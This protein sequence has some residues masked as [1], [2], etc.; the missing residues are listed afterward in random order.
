MNRP[1]ESDN[2]AAFPA[3][4]KRAAR[5]AI[6]RAFVLVGRDRRICQHLREAELTTLWLLEDWGLEWTVV[7]DHG[8]LEFHRGRVGKPNLTFAWRTAEAFF[9]QIETGLPVED[10][11]ELQGDPAWKKLCEPL[12]D[13]F[14]GSLRGVL[15]HPIDDA[16]ERLL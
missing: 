10:A 3:L 8:R 5:R 6:Q 9:S 4:S 14:C 12:Y 15:H 16:G 13:A 2:A 1:G 11:F 7:L